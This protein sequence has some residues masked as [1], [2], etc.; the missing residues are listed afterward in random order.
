MAQKTLFSNAAAPLLRCL[1]FR[2]DLGPYVV[3]CNYSTCQEWYWNDEYECKA[4]PA[5]GNRSV[6]RVAQRPGRHEA[7]CRRRRRSAVAVR[8]LTR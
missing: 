1:D 6:P 4:L 3:E 2:A 5:D 7:L 8:R